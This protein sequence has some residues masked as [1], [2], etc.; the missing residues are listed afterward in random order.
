MILQELDA[1]QNDTYQANDTYQDIDDDDDN[2]NDG[3]YDSEEEDSPNYHGK[4]GN[5]DSMH[6]VS[7]IIF[8]LINIPFPFFRLDLARTQQP[9]EAQCMLNRNS[10]HIKIITQQATRHTHQKYRRKRRCRKSS[11]EA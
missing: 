4:R 6:Q 7:T 1:E 5:R 2:D 9:N 10:R 8:E 3:Q 11:S